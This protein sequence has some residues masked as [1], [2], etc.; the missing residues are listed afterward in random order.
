MSEAVRIIAVRHG[1]TAWNADARVQGRLDIDLNNV[2]RWQA[3]RVAAALADETLHAIY[4]S[5]LARARDT[6]M[7]LAQQL[8]LPVNL[9]E[10]LRERGFGAF[11]GKTFAQIEAEQPDGARRWR[12]RDLHF[13]PGGHGESLTALY[14]RV[15]STVSRLAQ[16]HAGQHIA[17]FAHGGVMDMLYRAASR[18]PLEAPRT[19][20]LPNTAINRLLYNGEGFALVGWSDVAHL[21]APARACSPSP[22][23]S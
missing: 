7:P 18:I 8:G 22:G 3:E 14:E 16:A 19:W 20:Q 11:E 1:Q 17:V 15:V 4:S 9:E 10:G 6:A 23:R 21:E 5:D 2:G 12:E 13:R